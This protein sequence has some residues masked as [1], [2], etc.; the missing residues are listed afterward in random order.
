MHGDS[1]SLSLGLSRVL[2]GA[3]LVAIVACSA[4]SASPTSTSGGNAAGGAAAGGG[5]AGGGAATGAGSGGAPMAGAAG[6][7]SAAS[8]GAENSDAGTAGS[9]AAQSG[10]SGTAGA[11]GTG[12]GSTSNG[13]AAGA[14]PNLALNQPATA[15]SVEQGDHAAIRIN[16]GDLVTRW[17]SVMAVYPQWN[18]IDL[19]TP[20]RIDTVLVWPYMMRAYQFLLEGSLDGATYFTL[21]DQTTNTIGGDAIPVAFAAQSTRYVRITISGAS[22]YDKG[23]SAINEL[24]IFEAP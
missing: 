17:V 20:H 18:Q 14:R 7:S 16:D 12:G 9:V 13:G 15:S 24:Q 19:Q 3:G 6:S 2:L 4:P 8:G 11:G 5:T 10:A 21:S 23:W 22:V 1:S